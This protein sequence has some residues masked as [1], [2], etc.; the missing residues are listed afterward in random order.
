M[1]I[2]LSVWLLTAEYLGWHS[3][4]HCHLSD[5][6]VVT[7]LLLHYLIGKIPSGSTAG[8]THASTCILV[9][10][11]SSTWICIL[12]RKHSSKI[13]QTTESITVF[14][15]EHLLGVE[16]GL[17]LVLVGREELSVV[18]SVELASVAGFSEGEIQVL[19]V[20]ADPVTDSFSQGLLEIG[21]DW[22]VLLIH[23]RRASLG[24]ECRHL[25]GHLGEE[26]FLILALETRAVIFFNEVLHGARH[27]VALFEKV[28]RFSI[29]VLLGLQ[30]IAPVALDSTAE[31]VVLAL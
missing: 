3:I 26:L 19:A 18:L 1:K 2:R 23:G 20:Y 29:E 9:H 15:H 30:L 13:V 27:S 28:L 5:H 22:D 14:R 10:V 6:V 8:C 21:I 17:L 12:L 25:L 11:A 7:S 16:L 4:L 31:V 24:C